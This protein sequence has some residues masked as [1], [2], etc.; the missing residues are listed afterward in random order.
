MNSTPKVSIII[1]VYNMEKY[2]KE[3]LDS[4]ICQTLEDIEIICIDDCSTDSSLQILREYAQR[5]ARV[6]VFQNSMNQ[7][8]SYT[9]NIG[10]VNA[11]GEYIQFVDA[12][13]WV[14]PDTAEVLYRVAADNQLDLLRF[15]KTN[16]DKTLFGESVANQVFPSGVDLLEKLFC[17]RYFGIGPWLLFLSKHFVEKCQLRFDPKLTCAEDM[18]FSFQSMT[19]A[20]R[21]MCINEQK[22]KY[23]KRG[24]SL[25]TGPLSDQKVYSLIY[26]WKKMMDFCLTGWDDPRRRQITLIFLIEYFGVEKLYLDRSL[27]IPDMSRWEPELQKVYRIFFSGKGF[28]D[29]YID[30][31]KLSLNSELI[32]NAERIY[33]FGAGD[34]AQRLV[35]ILYR[36]GIEIDGVIVTNPA[37]NR[38]TVFG[39][40]VLSADKVR[41]EDGQP[42]I[43][44]AVKGVQ[45][46]INALLEA[47]GLHNVIYVCP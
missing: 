31:E 11:T 36:A 21:C 15:L 28:V 45:D 10:I 6:K 39:Y 37:K 12:D 25:S 4:V 16:Q 3:C 29:N 40:P 41:T 32:Y 20:E 42:L 22:Y 9:R 5:D 8:L 33:V 7:G 47:H 30:R 38:K 18:L 44:S 17:Q 2:L 35:Q 13:D 46:E 27:K 24:N 43:L 14:E 26:L 1:P 19:M 23:I 34:A